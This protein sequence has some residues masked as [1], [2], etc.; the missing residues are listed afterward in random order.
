MG[1]IKNFIKKQNGMYRVAF[2]VCILVLSAL[3]VTITENDKTAQA[4]VSVKNERVQNEIAS[5]QDV[6]DVVKGL[7]ETK[8]SA[9]VESVGETQPDTVEIIED[10]SFITPIYGKVQ[11]PFSI[12]VPVY[13]K[14]MD[15]WRI[16]EGV[17]I[18]CY[19]GAEVYAAQNGTVAEVGYD[20]NLGNYI[21][22]KNGEYELKYT[23]LSTDIKFNVGDKI[24]Q[25]QLIGTVSDSCISEICDEPHFHFEIKKNNEYVNP[26]EFIL[27]E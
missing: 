17:D 4:P 22:V 10:T 25:G 5:K 20:I 9:S 11:K 26:A 1:K 14:T 7:S 27:F 2:T 3:V 16:H 6:E 15:D 18:A 24:S 13:S 8:K 23:S 19:Y 12:D 21:V